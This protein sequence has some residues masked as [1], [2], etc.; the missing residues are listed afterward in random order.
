ML[1]DAPINWWATGLY[2]SVCVLLGMLLALRMM[3]HRDRSV[4]DVDDA[5]ADLDEA[6]EQLI[7]QAAKAWA[8]REGRPIGHA[9]VASSYA[10]L[11]ARLNGR[12]QRRQPYRSMR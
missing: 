3:D 5:E 6:T 7:E 8:E 2:G 1:I 11:A 12:A 4:P 9:H 10:K